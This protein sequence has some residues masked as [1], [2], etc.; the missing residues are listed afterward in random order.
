MEEKRKAIFRFFYFKKNLRSCTLFVGAVVLCLGLSFYKSSSGGAATFFGEIPKGLVELKDYRY[1]VYVFVPPGHDNFLFNSMLLLIPDTRETPDELVQ[2]W[3][4]VAKKRNLIVV[5]SDVQ[6]E[7]SDV[8]Y[9]TD[10]WMLKLKKD[11]ADRYHVGRTYLIGKGEGAHYAAYLAMQYPKEFSGAGLL[12]GSW[13]GPF[14]KLIRISDKP[15]AQVP[16]FIALY[17]P[18]AELMT[19]TESKAYQ[20][21]AKGYPVYLERFEKDEKVDAVD[22][23]T[24]MMDWLQ[25]K[26]ETWT[27]V[28]GKKGK[29]KKEK[30]S[31]WLG[32]FFASPSHH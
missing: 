23:K 11:M 3:L 32:E 14:E 5:V 1:P 6:R 9:H 30:F 20:L 24:R 17:A 29:T 13:T 15:V 25:K 16:F 4:Q 31:N 21:T 26:A 2:D 12:D 28:L 27:Q 7:R 22:M 8:P 19:Q 10:A 18:D